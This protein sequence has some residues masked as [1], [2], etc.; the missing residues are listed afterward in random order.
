MYSKAAEDEDKKLVERW[1][2]DADGILIFT[3]LFSAAVAALLA[4]TVQDLRQDPHSTSS[5]YLGN[6]YEVLADQNATQ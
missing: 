6:I 4:M 2:K 1:H 3:G 5:F